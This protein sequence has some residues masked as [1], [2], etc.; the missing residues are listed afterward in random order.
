MQFRKP[1]YD[2]LELSETIVHPS[3]DASAPP[4]TTIDRRPARRAL[5]L[6]VV[7]LVAKIVVLPIMAGRT[8]QW[9]LPLTGSAWA[10]TLLAVYAI[11]LAR[12]VE[13][14][15]DR[16]SDNQG[17]MMARYGLILG[18]ATIAYTA[19]LFVTSWIDRLIA[20]LQ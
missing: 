13:R 2:R 8:P 19:T 1:I 11:H 4:S 5:I 6:A 9:S 17:R 20:Y 15:I 3:R 12:Q 16:T 7:A 10:A 18:M 14:A